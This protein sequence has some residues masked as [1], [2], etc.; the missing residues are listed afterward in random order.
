MS[1]KI[2]QRIPKARIIYLTPNYAETESNISSQGWENAW[3]NSN[4]NTIYDF[5]KAIKDV[6]SWWGFPCVD[7]C[8]EWGI[9][10]Y[11]CTPYFSKNEPTK[12]HHPTSEGGKIMADLIYAKLVL[13]SN[14]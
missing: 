8:G 5:A 7:I 12:H 1:K 3:T 10:H 13:L 2:I 6:A 9:N 11:N 4:G 14:L